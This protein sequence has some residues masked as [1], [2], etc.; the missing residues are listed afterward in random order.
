M[1]HTPEGLV[2]PPRV[3]HALVQSSVDAR[4][5]TVISVRQVQ[6]AGVDSA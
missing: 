1:V 4:V 6:E 5:V 3:P 2:Q